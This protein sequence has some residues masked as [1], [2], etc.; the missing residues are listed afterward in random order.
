MKAFAENFSESE[1]TADTAGESNQPILHI[2]VTDNGCG[3]SDEM[4]RL[5]ED[6]DPES[7]TGHL[8]LANVGRMIQNL[9]K[10]MKKSN[11]K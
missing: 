1:D 7:L 3:I 8:G 5:L 4:L 6:T 10:H 2:T 9:S 11:P